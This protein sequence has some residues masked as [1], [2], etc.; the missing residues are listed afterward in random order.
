MSIP[1]DI[2]IDADAE[3][4]EAEQRKGVRH[5]KGSRWEPRF[6]L[7]KKVAALMTTRSGTWAVSSTP[8]SANQRRQ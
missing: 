7:Q 8:G 2:G 4:D 5:G 3:P 1:A 6:R